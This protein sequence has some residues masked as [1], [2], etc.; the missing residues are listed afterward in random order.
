MLMHKI[1]LS[2]TIVNKEGRSN[3]KI[4][5]TEKPLALCDQMETK[6]T[7]NK[8]HAKQLMRAVLKEAFAQKW[9]VVVGKFGKLGIML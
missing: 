9:R 5:C 6:I 3:L 1:N 8:T 2:K 7:E 4:S